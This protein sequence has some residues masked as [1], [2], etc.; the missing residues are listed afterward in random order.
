[1][2]NAKKSMSHLYY[3]VSFMTNFYFPKIVNK[4][5][6]K[7]LYLD[8]HTIQKIVEATGMLPVLTM[9]VVVCQLESPAPCYALCVAFCNMIFK[10]ILAFSI[11]VLISGIDFHKELEKSLDKVLVNFEKDLANSKSHENHKVR[12]NADAGYFPKIRKKKQKVRTCQNMA[13]II[14]GSNAFNFIN[15][16]AAVV[17]LVVNVNNNINNNNN[18]L[19]NINVNT[20]NA[21]NANVNA[22]NNGVN[23]VVVMPGR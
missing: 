23:S 12:R 18:N 9:P 16:V 1:M 15:F 4:T 8:N 10:Q 19:N 2:I 7:H 5:Q 17:T 22:N 3:L 21:N 6:C 20:N 11:F 14:G 13:G